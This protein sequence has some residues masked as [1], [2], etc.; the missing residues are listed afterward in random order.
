V[1]TNHREIMKRWAYATLCIAIL[2]GWCTQSQAQ[3]TPDWSSLRRHLTPEWLD[4][5]K[6]G[7]YCH[8]GP[9]SVIL[10]SQ[11]HEMSRLEAI[12]KWRG[13]KFSASEWVDLFESAGVQFIGIV[14]WHGTGLVNWDSQLTDWNTV[15]KGPRVDIVGELTREARKRDLKVLTSFHSTT[16][17]GPIS[18]TNRTYLDPR[19]E[20]SAPLKGPEGRRSDVAHEGWLARTSEIIEL[21]KP[22]MIWFDT[23][24]GGTVPGELKGRFSEGRLVDG[25]DNTVNGIREAYQQRVASFYFNKAQAW[26]KEVEFIY[27]SF[28]IPPGIGMRD[29]EDGNLKGLQYHPWMTDINMAKHRHYPTPWFY[30]PKNE[31][32]STDLLVDLLVDVTSKNGRVLLSVP[33]KADGSFSSDILKALTGIGQWLKVNGEAIYGTVPWVFFGEGPT[34]VTSPGHHGQGKQGGK[35]IAHYTAQDIRFTQTGNTLYAICLDWPG[36]ELRIRLL[37]YQGKLYPGDIKDVSL[38][39]YEGEISWEQQSDALHVRFPESKPCKY[40]YCL[41]ILRQLNGAQTV[42]SKP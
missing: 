28:D 27:K 22:D 37:G 12:E 5:M 21:Y 25:A 18:K 23:H 39:G 32:K 33:P 3:Y 11:N 2:I 19:K 41:K 7:I 30:N 15:K 34:A 10:E 31:I 20:E 35:H 13:D 17:W 24:F 14:A 26:G 1:R 29:I 36:N 16:I 6:F 8:W 9:Q 4:G 38:L 42:M 40:A